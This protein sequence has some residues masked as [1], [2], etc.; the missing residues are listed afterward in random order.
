MKRVRRLSLVHLAA[1][2]ILPWIILATTPAW[3]ES[4]PGSGQLAAGYLAQLLGGLVMV[5]LVIL[6]LAWFIRRVPGVQGQ[7]RSVIEVL[8]VRGIGTR[9]RL[10]LVQVGEEQVLIGVSPAGMSALHRLDKP[11][12]VTPEA[13]W[14]G[15]F[16]SILSRIK[17]SGSQS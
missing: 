14:A 2:W 1:R 5:I 13:Q 11:V 12:E 6:V 16:A 10:L 8:A 4:A 15:D 9:E 7:D 3:A 17:S